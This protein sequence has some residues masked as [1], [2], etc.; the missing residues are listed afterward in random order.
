MIFPTIAGLVESGAAPGH[1]FDGR[2][3]MP[4]L[5]GE[6]ASPNELFFYV[7]PDVVRG[8]RGSRWKMVVR[9]PGPDEVLRTELYDLA[10]DPY[11]RFDVAADHP[12]VVERLRSH[13]ERFAAESGARLESDD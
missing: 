11:E 7:Y 12:E 3:I 8:V 13:M 10:A 9:R 5:E 1:P 4:W 6:A 2:D